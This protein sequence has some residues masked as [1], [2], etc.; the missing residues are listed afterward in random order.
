VSVGIGAILW[1]TADSGSE[2]A[3]GTGPHRN[4]LPQLRLGV[5]HQGGFGEARWQF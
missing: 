5:G 4:V 2:Q 1:A 3:G